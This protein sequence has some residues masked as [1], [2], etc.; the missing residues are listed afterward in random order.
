MKRFI[1]SLALLLILCLAACGG[2]TEDPHPQAED[3]APEAATL[4]ETASG[5]SEEETLLTVDGRE[6]P[7][8]KYLY[9]LA[10]TCDRLTQRYAEARLPL[11]WSAPVSGGT[12]ADYAKDQALADAA[13]YAVVD[14]W[15]DAY[16]AMPG[17]DGGEGASL[18]A[19]GLSREQLDQLEET[20]RRYAALWTLCQSGESA[21]SPGPEDLSAFAR[22]A[23]AVTLDRILVP[24]GED[25]NAAREKASEL[26]AQLN[27]AEDQAARF[28]ELASSGGDPAGP[29]TV[30]PGD[31]SLED[32][33]LSAAQALGENQCSGILESQEG[34]SI[35]RRLPLD[36]Q[37]LLEAWFD[38][39]LERAAR[40]ARVTPAAGYADLDPAAFYDALLKARQNQGGASL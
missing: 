6:V 7:A 28:A 17:Q 29:R 16:G 31:G 11:D 34:F 21:L 5:L 8:W 36:P 24:P 35:L 20:G 30:L 37:P 38:D 14:N 4:L 13:L 22:E 40:E 10:Y 27:G 19:L 23:G 3:R 12:L 2:R 9:W 15:S 33:L 32:S 26:F 25:R 39:A 1:A 18:P